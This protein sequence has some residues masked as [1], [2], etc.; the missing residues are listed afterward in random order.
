LAPSL[1]FSAATAED[2]DLF[3]QPASEVE[4]LPN[5]LILL[6]N[7][8][9]WNTPFTNEK[10]ALAA[11]V[12][13]L[14]FNTDG[15]PKFRLGL[16]LFTETGSGDSNVDGGYIRAAIRDLTS[17]NKTKFVNLVNSLDVLADKSNGGKA[18]KTMAEAYVYFSGLAPYTGNNKNKTDY[19]NSVYGTAA[20]KAI[21]ACP[22]TRCPRRPD[23]RT[24]ARS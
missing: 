11:T 8:A 4:G 14:G 15:S 1:D 18:G 5:V 22:I 19:T 12:N 3:V 21:Y 13:G 10:A 24:R 7:T 6:D 17:A 16:M 23:R 2:I 9:N 20:S